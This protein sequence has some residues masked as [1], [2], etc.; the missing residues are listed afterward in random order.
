[1]TR[2][3][4]DL[5]W[6]KNMYEPANFKEY[7]YLIDGCIADIDILLHKRLKINDQLKELRALKKH[8]LANPIKD[9]EGDET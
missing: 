1:M 3:L 9:N 2:G 7:A 8:L 4:K 5:H 6:I